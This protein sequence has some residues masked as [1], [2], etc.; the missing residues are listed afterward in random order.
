MKGA[1]QGDGVGAGARARNS[2]KMLRNAGASGPVTRAGEQVQREGPR[3]S[4]SST[5]ALSGPRV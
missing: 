5:W 4:N 3:G 2:Q 1:G